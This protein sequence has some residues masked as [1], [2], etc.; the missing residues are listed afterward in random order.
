MIVVR[1][2]D[3]ETDQRRCADV[4]AAKDYAR[5]VAPAALWRGHRCLGWYDRWGHWHD[6]S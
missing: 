4:E 3:M 5:S 2:C 6:A 1:T